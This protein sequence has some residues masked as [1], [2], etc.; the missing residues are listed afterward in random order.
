MKG[1]EGEA[2]E[3]VV[4]VAVSVR[5]ESFEAAQRA[6]IPELGFLLASRGGPATEWW[7]AEDERYDGSD[8][9]SAIFVPMGQQHRES[10]RWCLDCDAEV[11][12]PRRGHNPYHALTNV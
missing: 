3:H 6:L 12:Y 1:C 9:E 4:L 5:G 10:H 7:I 8:N 11:P 2:A